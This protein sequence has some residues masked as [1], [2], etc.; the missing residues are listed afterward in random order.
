LIMASGFNEHSPQEG[1]EAIGE[2][3]HLEFK[4][5]FEDDPDEDDFGN[6]IGVPINPQPQLQT[7]SNPTPNSTPNFVPNLMPNP[8]SNNPM[9]VPPASVPIQSVVSYS[10]N[11]A[12]PAPAVVILQDQAQPEQ[13]QFIVQIP[14][15]HQHQNQKQKQVKRQP[16]QPKAQPSGQP[17]TQNQS[18]TKTPAQTMPKILPPAQPK[19]QAHAKKGAIHLGGDDD[20]NDDDDEEHNG[21]GEEEKGGASRTPTDH[22]N[23]RISFWE[24]SLW[25]VDTSIRSE[26]KNDGDESI[27]MAAMQ[28]EL[29]SPVGP[30]LTLRG[31]GKGVGRKRSSGRI[32]EVTDYQG[33]CGPLSRWWNKKS[34]KQV[35]KIPTVILRD[36]SGTIPFG[37][38]TA[39]LSPFPEESRA[40]L[41][42]LAGTKTHGEIEGQLVMQFPGAPAVYNPGIQGFGKKPKGKKNGPNPGD[43]NEQHPKFEPGAVGYLVGTG[44]GK[45]EAGLDTVLTH[46]TVREHLY[47]AARVRLPGSVSN[48]SV[49]EKVTSLMI[50]FGFKEFANVKINVPGTGKFEGLMLGRLEEKLMTLVVE[51]FTDPTVLFGDDPLDGL[52]ADEAFQYSFLLNRYI[53]KTGLTVI[54]RLDKPGTDIFHQLDHVVLLTDTG[55]L[56]YNGA[57]NKVVDYFGSFGHVCPPSESPARFLVLLFDEVHQ[58]TLQ[59]EALDPNIYVEKYREQLTDTVHP[60]SPSSKRP[61]HRIEYHT[62]GSVL[63]KAWVAVCRAW[64]VRWNTSLLFPGLVIFLLFVASQTTSFFDLPYDTRNGI[65]ARLSVLF[66]AC[67]TFFLIPAYFAETISEERYLAVRERRFGISSVFPYLLASYFVD[68]VTYSILSLVY[69]GLVYFAVPFVY[70]I[71]Y[72]EAVIFF[73]LNLVF[74]A[75]IGTSILQFFIDASKNKSRAMEWFFCYGLLFNVPLSGFFVRDYNVSVAWKYFVWTSPVHLGWSSLSLNEFLQNFR[76]EEYQMLT[77]DGIGLWRTNPLEGINEPILEAWQIL[78]VVVGVS[79]G[80]RLLSWVT[81]SFRRLY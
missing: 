81:L 72:Y 28:S 38:F 18:Q 47:Y 45:G 21:E 43:Q 9:P 22:V 39:I 37:V 36:L 33:R 67:F 79:I 26:P 61:Y 57:A 44:A 14:G 50:D 41:N 70:D 17:P 25:D 32:L 56:V 58:E 69:T 68:I 62:N 46:L 63:N 51:L 31:K 1:E 64:K 60:F 76:Y 59:K 15:K 78:I 8:L 16:V 19:L 13:P 4:N 49:M 54:F 77:L 73:F 2:G 5:T 34:A 7:R 65:L 74:M 12:A 10:N 23:R 3:N 71:L 29:N 75:D 6:F 52:T 40:L 48:N 27:D 66:I 35:A 24:L 30:G 53:K 80:L 11:A 42:L 20:E 55:D